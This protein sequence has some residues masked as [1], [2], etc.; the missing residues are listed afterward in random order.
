VYDYLPGSAMLMVRA[1]RDKLQQIV[2]NLLS[3]AV[4]F[5]DHGGR[6]TLAAEAEGDRV[7]IRVSDTG[8]GIP[9]EELEKIFEPFVQVDRGLTRTT[10]GTGLGLSISRDLARTMAGD[11][12]VAS[13]V[14]VGSTFTLSLPRG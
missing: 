4:K 5:T 12:R 6:I 8:R 2:L 3:N 10:E 9:A 14:G 7:C 11:L 1:D 13:E